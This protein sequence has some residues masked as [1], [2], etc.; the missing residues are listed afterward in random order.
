VMELDDA[1]VIRFEE[2]PEPS[3]TAATPTPAPSP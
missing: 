2:V 3:G 1:A